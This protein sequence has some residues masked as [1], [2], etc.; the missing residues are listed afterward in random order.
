MPKNNFASE[1]T[2]RGQAPF[3]RIAHRGASREAPENTIPAIRL[4]IQKYKVD[5]VEIDIRLT[6]EGVP[7]VIHDATLERT[8]NGKGKIRESS[9]AELKQWDAGAK[10]VTIP[11]L[12]EVLREFPETPFCLEI[13][14]KEIEAVKRVLEVIRPLARKGPLL[15]GSFYGKVAREL[16][17]LSPPSIEG[18]LSEDEVAWGYLAFRLGLR[19]FSF[20]SRYAFLPQARYGLRLDQ[21]EWIDFLHRQG[22]WVFYWTVNEVGQMKNLL[23][24]GVDGILSDY[25]D[26]LQSMTSKV[27]S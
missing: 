12:E 25:P 5:R 27:I 1:P 9:L 13:K 3:E 18:I 17:R 21:P 19:K 15:I 4:A 24:K 26:R 22:V 11:T 16:R 20:P 2:Q 23:S 14:D 8:T 6:R 7:V 10:G